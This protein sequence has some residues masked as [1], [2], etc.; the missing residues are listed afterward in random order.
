MA[1]ASE[2][3]Q[4][5]SPGSFNDFIV[6]HPELSEQ[7]AEE[8]YRRFGAQWVLFVEALASERGLTLE[9]LHRQTVDYSLSDKD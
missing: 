2:Q 1:G 3:S 6:A 5:L 8:R 4:H 7:T 9:E